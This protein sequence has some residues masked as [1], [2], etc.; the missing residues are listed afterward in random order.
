LFLAAN[1]ERLEEAMKTFDNTFADNLAIAEVVF[2]LWLTTHAPSP[3]PRNTTPM[4]TPLQSIH[5]LIPQDPHDYRSAKAMMADKNERRALKES[6]MGIRWQ[7]A[8]GGKYVEQRGWEESSRGKMHKLDLGTASGRCFLSVERW[9]EH[10]TAWT[11]ETSRSKIHKHDLHT[12]L[13]VLPS[14]QNEWLRLLMPW[15]CTVCLFGAHNSAGAVAIAATRRMLR[16]QGWALLQQ[17]AASPCFKGVDR[18]PC[19]DTQLQK[20]QCEIS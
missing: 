1:G 12:S 17:E 10:G 14:F 7:L 20:G 3:E 8:R 4:N 6:A 15:R 11:E 5:S 19:L 9:R 16:T 13:E 18:M 2:L